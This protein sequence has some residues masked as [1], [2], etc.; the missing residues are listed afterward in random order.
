MRTLIP[1]ALVLVLGCHKTHYSSDCTRAVALSPPWDTMKLPLD[2]N[3]RVCSSNDLK[4]D[5]EHL[6][7]DR[8]GWEGRY[9][10]AMTALGY[11]KER[12]SSTSCSY[13]KAGERVSVQVNQVA[14]G[15]KAKTIVH[16]NRT[17][18]PPPK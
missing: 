2:D 16:L 3:S 4:T 10:Q 1:L 18:A 7:G 6:D 9:D 17:P 14:A 13:T 5:V 11:T 8:A 15:K 12:C